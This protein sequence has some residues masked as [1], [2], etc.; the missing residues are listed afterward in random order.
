MSGLP[1]TIA[2]RLASW[3]SRRPDDLAY[4]WLSGLDVTG[5][6]TYGDLDQRARAIAGNL[7]D[8]QLHDTPVPLCYQAGLAFLEAFFGCLYAG[9]YPVPLPP[10]TT[11]VA[12]RGNIERIRA[13]VTDC[14]PIAVLT[15]NADVE[16]LKAALVDVRSSVKIL[17]HD[18]VSKA[19]AGPRTFAPGEIAFIQYSS[20]STRNPRGIVITHANVIANQEMIQSGFKMEPGYMTG[21]WLPPYHDMGLVGLV[22][23]PL[24]QGLPC[25]LMA[26]EAFARDPLRWLQMIS[27]FR[28]NASGAPCFAY[29]YCTRRLDPLK[30]VDVDL[31]CWHVA[32]NGA[33]MI[34]RSVLEAFTRTFRLYG[35]NSR[36]MYCCYGMA[37]ATL[38]VTGVAKDTG[39]KSLDVAR[40]T[41]D[42]GRRVEQ[43]APNAGRAL[44]SC[45]GRL[46][47]ETVEILAPHGD[48]VLPEGHVG[49][50][51]VKG[52]HMARALY[53]GGRY[54][55][56]PRDG[57]GFF[58]TGDSGF[59]WRGELYVVGRLKNGA[60]VRGRTIFAEDIEAMLAASL[61][62][63]ELR[64][65]VAMIAP[66]ELALAVEVKPK[67]ANNRQYEGIWRRAAAEVVNSFGLTL[68]RILFVDKGTLTF[69]TSGKLERG[70]FLLRLRE[71]LVATTLI[72]TPATYRRQGGVGSCRPGNGPARE[73]REHLRSFLQEQIAKIL[74]VEPFEIDPGTRFTQLGLDSMSIMAI[75]AELERKLKRQ[76]SS[77]VI[78]D[79]P[80]I[81]AVCD[82]LGKTGA[83]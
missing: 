5:K 28:I 80:T 21:G 23:A 72:A 83:A 20:G 15:H 1:E 54:D 33:D 34:S 42:L 75:A 74:Q 36:A 73:E 31:S 82:Y 60:K 78:W 50:I 58:R 3:A 65:L 8:H 55:D 27:K 61:R 9:A 46:P 7:R 66:D 69:T 63:M 49:E 77:Q 18:E 41:L 79:H 45:G 17:G 47:G 64:G 2:S 51:G 6:V 19:Y 38:M 35:F 14:R 81:D 57:R 30:L 32:F 68:D 70:R 48:E 24:F 59:F 13:A 4:A 56:I 71:G 43:V 52:S 12:S 39:Y 62:D 29:D 10:G 26:P 40:D 11:A 53:G 16:A 22:L 44:V 76:V 25:Y 67:A 37:E